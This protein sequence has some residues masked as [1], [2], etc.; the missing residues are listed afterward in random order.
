MVE[1]IYSDL[2]R[3]TC[4]KYVHKSGV[5]IF[6]YPM[7]KSL[8]CAQ[9]SVKFGA[10]DNRYR[11]KGGELIEIP[12]GTAHYL[13]HKLFESEENDAFGLFA[14]TGASCNAGT[15]YES[16]VYY[17]SCTDNFEKNLEILLGFVQQPYFTPE[18]VEKERGII[19]QEITM[20]DDSPGWRVIAELLKGVYQVNPIRNDI[21]GTVES[22]ADITDKL[23]YE[24]YDVFYNP[25]NMYLCVAGKID[26]DKVIEIC[27][28]C[29]KPREPLDFETAPRQEPSEVGEKYREVSMA[30]AK[31]LFAIGFKRPDSDGERALEEYVYYNIIFDALFSDSSE[32]YSVRRE[33]GLLNENFRDGVFMGRNYVMPYISGESDDPERVLNEVK[34]EIM[35]FKSEGIPESVFKRIKKVNYGNMLRSF[36]NVESVAENVTSAAMS[37]VSPFATIE[38]IAR[39]DYSVMQKKLAELD[40]E[41][42]CL[43]VVKPIQ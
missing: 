42:V 38:M 2:V 25:A 11:I 12:D 16:T 39:A 13:E 40:V 22:I 10:I 15:S 34:S 26:P 41:N 4:L 1:K 20:Y 36:N 23:L 19:G 37:G 32:F 3:E 33:Q 8:A 31:P 28:R 27:D 43:S 9:F 14:Q 7:D 35:R 29:L 18:T 5:T 6:M 21:A 30:V 24:V 17:F